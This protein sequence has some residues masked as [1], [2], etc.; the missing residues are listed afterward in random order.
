MR[1]IAF[2][3]GVLRL[4]NDPCWIQAYPTG[5]ALGLIMS[6]GKTSSLVGTLEMP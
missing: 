3:D 6:S 2:I 4:L 1:R 5:I